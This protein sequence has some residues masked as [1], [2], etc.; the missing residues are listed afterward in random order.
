[1][2]DQTSVQE[3]QTQNLQVTENWVNIKPVARLNHYEMEVQDH[4]NMGRHHNNGSK[5]SQWNYVRQTQV[6]YVRYLMCRVEQE[7]RSL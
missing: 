6:A 5:N 3:T 7:L 1:M 4:H 2:L